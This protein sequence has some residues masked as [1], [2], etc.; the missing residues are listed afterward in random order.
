MLYAKR[1]KLL[2]L[3]TMLA[4]K[5]YLCLV[6]LV[7][8][9]LGCGHLPDR[10]VL[11]QA[12]TIQALSAGDY[13]GQ[14]TLCALKGHGDFGLGTFQ[15]LDGEMVALDGLFYQVKV[16][17]HVYPVNEAEGI[18]FAQVTF[19]DTDKTFAVDNEL[20]YAELRQ[21]LDKLLSSKNIFYAVKISGLFKYVKTRSVPKQVKPYSG[22]DQAVKEQKVFEFHDIRGSVVGWRSPEYFKGFSVGGYHLHFISEDR[23][24]GGHLLDFQTSGV[25][26]EIDETTDFYL[27]LPTNEEFLGLNLNAEE[28]KAGVSE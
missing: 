16:N 21:Y 15:G 3:Y 27:S 14:V 22:L 9:L 8:N 25:I 10:E 20:S 12:S 17:G 11:Y 28:A 19:F 6:I 23:L 2:L 5:S 24:S 7:F 26:I 4:N 1:L 13:D 18:P